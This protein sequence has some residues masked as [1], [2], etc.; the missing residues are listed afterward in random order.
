MI[1]LKN[2][3]KYILQNKKSAFSQLIHIGRSIQLI[4]CFSIK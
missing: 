2:F 1:L 3:T 4:K